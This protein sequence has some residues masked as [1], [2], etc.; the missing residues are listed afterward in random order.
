MMKRAG[1]YIMGTMLLLVLFANACASNDDPAPSPVVAEKAYCT[2]VSN[3]SSPATIT[4]QAVYKYRL[5]TT[6]GLSAVQAGSNPIRYAEVRALNSN[7]DTVQ[8]GETDASGNFSI[9]VPTSSSAITIVVAARAYNSHNKASILKDPV[10]NDYHKITTTAT[11]DS[12]KS[13]GTMTASATGTLE[14]GAFNILDKILTANEYIKTQTAGCSFS[15]S[16]GGQSF[17]CTPFTVDHKVQVYWKPGF[18]PATYIGGSATQTL[19]FYS[20]DEDK[21]FLCGGVNGNVDDKDT[22]HYDNSIIIH[23]YGHFLEAHYSRSDSPGG[24]HSG[25]HA[26]DP[27]LAFSEGFANFLQAAALNSPY[28]IDTIG[29]VDG[30]TSTGFALSTEYKCGVNNTGAGGANCVDTSTAVGEGNFREFG[31]TRAL[32]D[33]IDTNNDANVT[34]GVSGTFDEIWTAWRAL[35]SL[36]VAFRNIGLLYEVQAAITSPSPTNISGVYADENQ[37]GDRKYYANPRNA[38]NTSCTTTVSSSASHNNVDDFT[39]NQLYSAFNYFHLAWA[40]GT[41]TFQLSY[42]PSPG[43][44]DLDLFIYRE[45]HVLFDTDYIVNLNDSPNDN[46]NISLS[47]GMPPGN[48]MVV[49]QQYSGTGSVNYTLTV[50]GSK[51]CPTF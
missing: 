49:V 2:T 19:S 21:L 23:E 36:S 50:G 42:N 35:G 27:R 37:Y 34:D 20:P 33:M 44:H 7:G 30:T 17:S 40:G 28:Y 46:G 31:I 38:S 10:S 5:P 16:F 11:P 22:D 9:N 18:N 6:T 15:G 45:D 47:A 13:V 48:Y 41:A 4:G 43:S 26:I 51:I 1:F 32:W 3:Y 12:S 29:N 39:G 25:E 8:C 14:G 24:S